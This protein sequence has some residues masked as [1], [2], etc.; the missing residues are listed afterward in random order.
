MGV[1]LPVDLFSFLVIH[2]HEIK[3]NLFVIVHLISPLLYSA[4]SD[5]VIQVLSSKSIRV[6]WTT[7]PNAERL[8]LTY[9]VGYSS[10]FTG[11]MSTSTTELSLVLTW[12]HPFDEYTVTVESYNKGG[13]GG[14]IVRQATTLS[15]G[16]C[17]FLYTSHNPAITKR[18]TYTIACF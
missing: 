11:R 6:T 9:H 4:P 13:R 10:E 7:P 17:L 12:L 2:L 1:S 8:P 18:S 16:M 14:Y 15:A 5:L 3:A